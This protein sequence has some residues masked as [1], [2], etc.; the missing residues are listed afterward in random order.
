VKR[1]LTILLLLLSLGVQAFELNVTTLTNN[2]G[3]EGDSYFN[4]PFGN[5]APSTGD[6]FPDYLA[7]YLQTRYPDHYWRCATFGRSGGTDQ[8]TLT[9]VLHPFILPWM[10]YRS[11]DNQTLLFMKGTENGFVSFATTL[12]AFS[13]FFLAPATMSSGNATLGS[14][15]GWA[16]THSYDKYGLGDFPAQ[17]AD[18]RIATRGAESD[19]ATNAGIVFGS[20]GIDIYHH[21]KV[22]FSNDFENTGGANVWTSD[23]DHPGPVG[24]M[25]ALLAVVKQITTST[26][27]SDAML[28]WNTTG[29][30]YTNGC[31][32]TGIS[33]NGNTLT[34]TRHDDH[35]RFAWDEPNAATGI[36]N[37]CNYWFTL[38]PADATYFNFGMGISNLPAGNWLITC[39]GI[40]IGIVS[41]TV[42]SGDWNMFTNYLHPEWLQAVEALGLNRDFNGANRVS[43]IPVNGVN[44]Q[45]WGSFANSKWQ[46]GDRG[47]QLIADLTA[48]S[49]A[50]T[51]LLNSIH[52][53]VQP[54]NLVY[55]ATLVTPRYAPAVVEIEKPLEWVWN[56]GG[57]SQFLVMASESL[58]RPLQ[59]WDW[60]QV[61][62]TNNFF[63]FPDRAHRFFAVAGIDACGHWDW[64]VA[65]P[66]QP[67]FQPP[68]LNY[69]L[70]TRN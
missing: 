12:N 52:S 4:F 54:T 63:M 13:N 64:C 22:A 53:Q 28:D 65:D 2:V 15:T 3:I 10:G 35:I 18:G 36:T 70:S 68:A 42:L 69:Q 44:W 41:S 6:M 55:T 50:L 57:Y 46:A 39:G 40:N 56:P 67:G 51:N 29:I 32:V 17:Q 30:V 49:D 38:N 61:R 62:N 14:I 43:L 8:D 5:P 47:D 16:A 45:A 21:V 34:W 58:E 1:L 7:T 26:V 25:G 20:G 48:N 24:H 27:I 66:T 9:N 37:D 31:T 60:F 59:S 23:P 19:A 33:K 11:N